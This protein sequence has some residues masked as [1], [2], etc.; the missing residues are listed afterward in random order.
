MPRNGPVAQGMRREFRRLISKFG[1]KGCINLYL[2][3]GVYNFYLK[4]EG[5]GCSV[6]PE[7][8]A[9]VEVDKGSSGGSRRALKP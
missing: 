9:P 5:K 6:K 4:M 1:T 7:T 3:N 8:I 2:E